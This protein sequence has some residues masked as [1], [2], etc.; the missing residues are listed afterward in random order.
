M[1]RMISALLLTALSMWPAEARAFKQ[2]RTAATADSF[3]SVSAIVHALDSSVFRTSFMDQWQGV[4][5]F[6]SRIT[7]TASNLA[8]GVWLKNRFESYGLGVHVVEIDTPAL[9]NDINGHKNINVIARLP[10][11]VHPDKTVVMCAHFDTN[12]AGTPGADDNAVSV[13]V[14]L[15]AAKTLRGFT[16]ENS[17][18]FLCSNGHEQ[19]HW[20]ARDY[21]Q[22]AR[23]GGMNI[24]CCINL[25]MISWRGSD[26]DP[27]DMIIYSDQPGRI[28]N[29]LGNTVRDLTN[30]YYSSALQPVIEGFT[31][32]CDQVSFWDNGYKAVWITHARIYDND[33]EWSPYHHALNDSIVKYAPY[34]QPVSIARTSIAA[35]AYYAVPNGTTSA[36]RSVA[37][38]ASVMS[39]GIVGADIAAEGLHIRLNSRHGCAAKVVLCTVQG[40]IVGEWTVAAP[41]GVD[42]VLLPTGHLTAGSY[43]A[44]FVGEAANGADVAVRMVDR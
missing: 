19:N 23:A 18:E 20:G 26:P 4:F 5:S 32:N 44:R 12:P 28:S 21:A 14:L 10:G 16:F 2:A 31:A 6:G 9:A 3:A 42:D 40:R 27:A 34:D 13:A 30:Y 41:V 39:P 36:G 17:I 33:P 37:I 8:C 22:K 7:G 35:A 15:E 24:L 43:F 38:S 1:T 29:A 25:D 11:T